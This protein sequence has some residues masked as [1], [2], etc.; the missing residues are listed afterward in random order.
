MTSPRALE[1]R[2]ATP[3]DV[4]VISRFNLLLAQETE[5]RVLDA[6]RVHAGVAAALADPD[7]G[8][9]LVA[10]AEGEVVGQVMI[11]REWSDWRN[12][13]FWWLQSVY[14]QPARRGEGVFRALFAAVEA[15][16]TEDGAVSGLR[17]YVERENRRALETYARLGLVDPG[18]RMLEADWS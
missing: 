10:A 9:Y 6:Q 17:L 2:D 4:E 12:M 15:L 18:Y 7:R 5:D 8:R 1:I 11:T 13:W 14:V 16:A 3:E